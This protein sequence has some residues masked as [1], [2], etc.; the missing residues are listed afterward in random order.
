MNHFIYILY[1][2]LFSALKEALRGVRSLCLNSG[3]NVSINIKK[4]YY[5]YTRCLHNETL[6]LG[7][8]WAVDCVI[9]CFNIL[10]SIDYNYTILRTECIAV[11]NQ[12]NGIEIC[13]LSLL[14]R[15]DRHYF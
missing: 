1:A 4:F 3:N 7:A 13:I 6:I 5:R 11:P 12:W 14:K 8:H 2:G 9:Q 10:G 15:D